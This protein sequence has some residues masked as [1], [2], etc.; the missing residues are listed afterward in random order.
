MPQWRGQSQVQGQVYQSQ[1]QSFPEVQL[2]LDPG[3]VQML[4]P[5]TD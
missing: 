5:Q 4:N 2:L 1:E 3:L